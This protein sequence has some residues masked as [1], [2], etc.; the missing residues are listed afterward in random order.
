M[1]PA[2]LRAEFSGRDNDKS[3]G[4]EAWSVSGTKIKPEQQLQ[5]QDQGNRINQVKEIGKTL[6]MGA[7]EAMERSLDLD[8][9]LDVGVNQQKGFQQRKSEVVL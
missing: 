9:T 4:N 2:V 7:S 5:S 3:K 1:K 6:V 8:F